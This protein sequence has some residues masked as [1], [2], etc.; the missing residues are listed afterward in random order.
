VP[1]DQVKTIQTAN[2]TLE[3]ERLEQQGGGISPGNYIILTVIDT[4]IGMSE[5]V[6]ARIFEPFFTTKEVGQG[7]G[8]GLPTSYGI[9]TQNGGHIL[10]DSEP[11]NGATFEIYLPRF[12]ETPG[13]C[14]GFN[15]IPI[16]LPGRQS[17]I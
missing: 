10:V 17:T 13:R 15:D 6:K 12:E 14:A 1:R 7:P 5:A 16:H 2:V 3:Q 11:G 9:L 8:L 4:G